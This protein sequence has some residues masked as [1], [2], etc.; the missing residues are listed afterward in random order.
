[1]LISVAILPPTVSFALDV[2][3]FAPASVL[4][5]GKWVKI[6][7]A[8][9]GINIISLA[10]LRSM[11][12]SNP[13]KVHVYGTGGGMLREEL[14]AGMLDDLPLQPSLMTSRGLLFFA[15]G[16]NTW[17]KSGDLYAHTSN[18][19]NDNSYYF[20]SDIEPNKEI[21]ITPYASGNIPVSSSVINSFI[22]RDLHERDLAAPDETGRLL[23][24]E[25][26]RT[27][28]QQSFNF[29]ITDKAEGPVAVRVAFGTKT[30]N[31]SSTLMFTANG[32]QLPS[33]TA[34]VIPP[35]GTDNFIRTTISEKE[36]E[37]DGN[38][39]NLGIK[40]SNSG[41]LFTAR[42]DYIEVFYRRKLKLH[43][44]QLHFYS[45]FA[46]GDIVEIDGCN[47]NTEVWDITDPM[48]PEIVKP[49]HS[50]GKVYI[51]IVNEGYR[52]FVAF[53]P[54]IKAPNA[55]IAGRVA[56]Q[57]IHGMDAPDMLIISP[58][59]YAEGARIIAEMHEK[60]DGMRVAVLTPESIYNEFSGGHPDV[61]AFRKL[62]KMWYDRSGDNGI[63]YCLLMGRGSYD[64][65]MATSDL[66]QSG[67]T[68]LVMWQ[69]P[70]GESEI[71]SF[72]NDDII[73]ML[74]DT[75]EENFDMDSAKIHVAVG[76]LPVKSATE[77]VAVARKISKYSTSPEYGTW[78]NRVM[79]IADDNDNGIHLN[80]SEQVYDILKE[81]APSF[82]YE[83]VYLDSY[84][85]EYTGSGHSYPKAKEKILRMFNE[86]VLFTNYIGHGSPTG[87]T[88]EKLLEWKDFQSFS[89][90]NLSLLYA[91]TCGFGKWDGNSV[92]GAETLLLNPTAGMAGIITATRTVYMQPNGL[93]NTAVAEYLLASGNGESLRLGDIYRKGKNK[94]KDNNKHRFCLMGDPALRIPLPT[95]QVKI[96]SINNINLDSDSIPELQALDR[97]R[98]EGNILDSQG[99][100]DNTFNGIIYIDLY[101]A[102]C[103][104]ETNG[105]GETGVVSVYNDRKN[106]LT[107]VSAKVENGRWSSVVTVPAEIDNNYSPARL[108]GYAYS[109][110]GVEAHGSTERLYV[111]GFPQE[112]VVE[113]T[114][115]PQIHAYYI[116]S[117]TFKSGDQ[118]NSNPVV[119]ARFSDPSGINISETGIG[120]RMML[121]L[122]GS[123]H[124]DDLASYY[125]P[126]A[127][128]EGGGAI[129]YPMHDLAPGR[130]ELELTVYDNAGNATRS[131]IEF[132]VSPYKDP[133][134]IELRTDRNPASTA[135]VFEVKIDMPNT[136]MSCVLDVYDLNGRKV[137]T[138]KGK[139]PSD[140]YGSIQ[141]DWNLVDA[142]GSR[143]PRG[144]YLYRVNVETPEGM[145]SSKTKKLAVTAR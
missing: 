15:R 135:V 32:E 116:N 136:A 101:D 81:K 84:P 143:V 97:I 75:T 37:L 67:Y 126:D 108:V 118:V 124:F 34:D 4:A 145:Y 58:G 127:E 123:K 21:G 7:V 56:N 44:N 33:T 128:T 54:E 95:H 130:H 141:F 16:I 140:M 138:T 89:N 109:P 107:S 17:R 112:P 110:Q 3:C 62:L 113:D 9:E 80:Q 35:C 1:M 18:P 24:G 111:Y 129:C 65:K 68:P 60:Q 104:I 55:V 132:I 85:L 134:I 25:D 114:E 93:L 122:D 48:N 92:S 69:S 57:N 29:D 39:L 38:K 12:F 41:A 36:F 117:E 115:G 91:S 74:A 11:G 78:R 83:R 66:R 49:E 53:N 63:K 96:K 88:H 30:T 46:P 103:P 94:L 99:K 27:E 142:S 76:R 144:I 28:R 52:E 119:F 90:K 2:S 6:K 71:T 106:R 121:I 23:L 5:S 72:C 14:T 125:I 82:R 50:D 77:A 131:L 51:S 10:D 43:N 87:W 40:Y 31:G 70:E 86:G 100:E 137:W 120:A 79:L 42:L 139:I 105:N 13:E 19:Y 73:G 59:E 133:L 98:L 45:T 8:E 102:E 61:I 20:L 47:E 22:S 64:S 26:F